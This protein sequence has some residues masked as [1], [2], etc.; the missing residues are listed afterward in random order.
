MNP[1]SLLISEL[2]T[3]RRKLL[4]VRLPARIWRG[5]GQTKTT[6]VS[7]FFLHVGTGQF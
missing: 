2:E 3:K 4:F 1:N 7:L 5:H 6:N